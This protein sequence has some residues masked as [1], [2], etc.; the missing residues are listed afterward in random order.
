MASGR[1][2][3]LIKK[4]HSI[5]DCRRGA[6]AVYKWLLGRQASASQFAKP[7]AC[8]VGFLAVALIYIYLVS[9]CPYAHINTH[10][11]IPQ[12]QPYTP[13]STQTTMRLRFSVKRASLSWRARKSNEQTQM[14][15]RQRV[16]SAGSARTTFTRFRRRSRAAIVRKVK[17]KMCFFSN[18]IYRKEHI[19]SLLAYLFVHSAA[20]SPHTPPT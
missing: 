20:Q 4:K 9:L 5:L 17:K 7:G 13:H 1:Q 8:L 14:R 6:A 12:S 10:A 11:Q 19:T 3:I 16:R 18:I 2:I 15:T